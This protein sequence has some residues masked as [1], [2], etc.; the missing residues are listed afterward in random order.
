MQTQNNVSIFC[1]FQF[2]VLPLTASDFTKEIYDV[3]FSNKVIK[4]QQTKINNIEIELSPI[5]LSFDP[6]YYY[7][8]MEHNNASIAKFKQTAQLQVR[9]LGTDFV[10][11]NYKRLRFNKAGTYNICYNDGAKTSSSTYLNI[12]FFETGLD[13]SDKN[14][15]I[16]FPIEDKN[17]FWMKISKSITVPVKK[18]AEMQ[19]ELAGAVLD[20]EGFSRIMINK[21]AG[22]SVN[23]I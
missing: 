20:G 1:N 21:V 23:I 5:K 11:P 8:I 2:A 17:S 14:D 6:V 9:F 15:A 3:R 10:P 13:I 18:D 4:E 12:K 22:F 16:Q 19:I 7:G